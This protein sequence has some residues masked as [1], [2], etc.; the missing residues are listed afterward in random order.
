LAPDAAKGAKWLADAFIQLIQ[1]I[2]G[3]VSFVTV[4]VGIA[5]LGSL[6]RFERG[7]EIVL[8]GT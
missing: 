8:P 4:V 6:A 1:T 3:P 5:S 7:P 2:T